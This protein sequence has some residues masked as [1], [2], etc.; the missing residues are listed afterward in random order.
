MSR[1]IQTECQIYLYSCPYSPLYGYYVNPSRPLNE[2]HHR[3]KAKKIIHLFNFRLRL[4]LRASC[5][6]TET[7]NTNK[8][9]KLETKLARKLVTVI[10]SSYT[11][12]QWNAI[13]VLMPV[14]SEC[15]RIQSL[16]FYSV[17]ELKTELPMY[18][19][20]EKWLQN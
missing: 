16:L 3:T 6:T 11:S 13:L 19:D 9:L 2:F 15:K 5:L 8:T 12:V 4:G 10:T 20:T 18:T 17:S 1:V 14:R 7:N